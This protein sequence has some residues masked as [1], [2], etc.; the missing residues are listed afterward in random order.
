M[1]EQLDTNVV[2]TKAKLEID[3]LQVIK[4]IGKGGFSKVLLV[5]DRESKKEYALKLL[6]KEKFDSTRIL[7]EINAHK[8]INNYPNSVKCYKVGLHNKELYI[9][10]DYAKQGSLYK[11]V[12]ENDV[13]NQEQIF[14]LLENVLDQMLFARSNN[15][16]HCD[17]TVYNTVLFKDQF[18]LIDWGLAKSDFIVTDLKGHRTYLAPEVYS[19]KRSFASEI[20]SLGAVLYFASTGKPLFDIY[21]RDIPFEQKVFKHLYYKPEFDDS[22]SEKT[23]YLIFRMLE[24]D[25]NKRATV[26]EIQEIIQDG[27]IVPEYTYPHDE[28]AS[29]YN[30]D[31]SF[32]LYKKMADD[33]VS[34]AQYRMGRF[35]E[36][37]KNVE[38]NS[39]L[40]NFWYSKSISTGY[41]VSLNKVLRKLNKLNI[42]ILKESK[43]SN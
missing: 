5:R 4:E 15:L 40:A 29:N 43:E 18:S 31:D 34:H 9:L 21:G 27:F 3:N 23:K 24:K 17:I 10:F 37:G 1:N 20:Y 7:T 26:Q 11:H 41:V 25:F 39:R 38:Q 8:I 13:L 42:E 33:G 14:K 30:L 6:K 36:K 12:K 19:G 35:Y 16:F 28:E 32:S 22:V 2:Q